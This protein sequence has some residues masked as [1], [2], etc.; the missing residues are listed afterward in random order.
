M[1][2]K[3]V[4]AREMLANNEPADWY[5]PVPDRWAPLVAVV[6]ALKILGCVRLRSDRFPGFKWILG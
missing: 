4:A 5:Y 6:L 2:M 1:W 3:A